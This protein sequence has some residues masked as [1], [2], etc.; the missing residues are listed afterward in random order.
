V[1][2]ELSALGKIN[3]GTPSVYRTHDSPDAERIENLAQ[4]LKVMGYNLNVREGGKVSGT[5]LNK[6]MS[7]VKGKPEEYLIK[8]ATLR[9]MAKAIYTT[10]NI[11]HFGL[12]FEFYTHFTS[13]IRRYPDVLVHRMLKHYVSGDPV[14]KEQ[15]EEFEQLAYHSSEREVAASEAERDSIKMKQVEFLAGRIGEEFEGVI[16]G[17][18]DRG[19]Y[20]ELN[21]TR[22]DGMVRISAIGNDY[23]IHD[24]KRYRLVGERTKKEYALGDP[25]KVRLIAARVPERELDFELVQK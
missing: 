12:A 10:K 19:I 3:G 17:V 18:T 21:E 15:M 8:M 14:S 5:D 23:F 13:P 25:V 9:S 22:A 1:A 6:L 2:E 24:Q 20:V 16:S 4:F 7:E 11:G